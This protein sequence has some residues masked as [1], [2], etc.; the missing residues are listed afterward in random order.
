M[1]PTKPFDAAGHNFSPC[2]T[3]E[4]Y[5]CGASPTVIVVDHVTPQTLLCGTHFFN[6][7]T[8]VDWDLWNDQQEGT[9]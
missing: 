1:P 3:A 4:C 6:D 8:M 9:E 2:F 7:R 5:V